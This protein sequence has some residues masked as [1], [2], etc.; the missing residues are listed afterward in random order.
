MAAYAGIDN[1]E[2][3][4]VGDLNGGNGGSGFSDAWGTTTLVDVQSTVTR[5][6][7]STRAVTV[8]AANVPSEPYIA[9]TLTTG[10]DSGD[11]YGSMRKSLT[12]GVQDYFFYGG[13]T[14]AFYVRFDSAG[15]IN[16]VGTTTVAI[17]TSPSA[18]QWYDINVNWVSA[19]SVKARYKLNTDT[20]WGSFTTAVTLSGGISSITIVK[21]GC[22]NNGTAPDM[23]WDDIQNTD[24]TPVTATSG[25]NFPTL[26][27]LG[28][29]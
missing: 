7:S 22:Q 14:L 3:Y 2:S 5:N 12:S 8:T 27:L 25:K 23:Y 1:F 19:T 13:A 15:N 16:L 11:F 9:R 4:S 28:V 17:V 18:N 24:P 20:S 26:T 6:A 29:G 21:I 10:A